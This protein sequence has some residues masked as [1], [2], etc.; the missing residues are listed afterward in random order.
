MFN[1]L[2]NKWKNKNISEVVPACWSLFLSLALQELR[3]WQLQVLSQ[4]MAQNDKVEFS[5]GILWILDL[6]GDP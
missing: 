5:S 2:L 3:Q 4:H 1:K 6:G